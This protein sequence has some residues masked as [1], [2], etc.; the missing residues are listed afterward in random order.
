[1]QFMKYSNYSNFFF[2]NPIEIVNDIIIYHTLFLTK[3]KSCIVLVLRFTI[4][5]IFKIKMTD[6]KT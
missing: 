1:M 2:H 3:A 4:H 6:S 5:C